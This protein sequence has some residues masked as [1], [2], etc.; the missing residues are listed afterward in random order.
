MSNRKTD[1]LLMVA[2]A[3]ALI[4]TVYVFYI[5]VF[6]QII[7]QNQGYFYAVI[8]GFILLVLFLLCNLFT[9]LIAISV[10]DQRTPYRKLITTIG[11]V[12]IAGLFLVTRMRY[13][14]SLYPGDY[15]VFRGAAAMAEGTYAENL[16]LIDSA[17]ANPAHYLCSLLLSVVFRIVEPSATAFLWMNAI[18]IVLCGFLT[19]KIVRAFTNPMCGLFSA[20]V[21]ACVPSQTFA[22]YSLNTEPMVAAIYLGAVLSLISLFSYNKRVKEKEE[23][24]EDIEEDEKRDLAGILFT[25]LGT[26]LI[27]LLIFVEPFMIIPMALL[28]LAAY[29]GRKMKALNMLVAFAAGIVVMVLLCF[30]KSVHMDVDFGTVMKSEV[31]AFDPSTNYNTG[32]VS[33][34]G[35]VY[36]SFNVD[37]SSTDKNITENYMF[38]ST[39]D[40]AGA[41]TEMNASWVVV[42]NQIMY[43]FVLMMTISCMILAVKEQKDYVVTIST[44]IVGAFLMLFFQQNRDNQ[45]FL[46]IT[47]F[48]IASSTGIHYLYLDHHPELKVSVNALDALEKTGRKEIAAATRSNL[49]NAARMSEA[50]FV[51]RAKAL[52]FVGNDEALY[53]QIKDEEHERAL[54]YYQRPEKREEEAF[55]DYDDDFFLDNE[56]DAGD[57]I[58]VTAVSSTGI[59]QTVGKDDMYEPN[60]EMHESASAA[61]KNTSV[62]AWKRPEQFGDEE[63]FDEDD[64]EL[65]KAHSAFDGRQALAANEGLTTKEPEPEVQKISRTGKT[66]KISSPK[67]NKKAV[68]VPVPVKKPVP[69]IE[70]ETAAFED[71]FGYN[72]FDDMAIYEPQDY[73]EPVAAKPSKTASKISKKDAKKEAK[74]KPKK[75][76][77]KA[78]KV[79]SEASATNTMSGGKAVRRIKT[80]GSG[81]GTGVNPGKPLANPLPVPEKKPHKDLDYDKDVK[82]ADDDGWDFDVDVDDSDDWDI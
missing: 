3:L 31:S 2:A 67:S 42:L 62:P 61:R 36:H 15:P 75:E 79:S 60:A 59:R 45:E 21:F 78:V 10:G 9:K 56:D 12:V 53:N 20:I 68:S 77:A 51:K 32:E 40:G 19:Y 70:P 72:D 4:A 27:G 57:N 13:N 76:K 18:F 63:M 16:D 29:I 50:D 6:E 11:L 49:K 55:D 1:P 46:F 69:V 39:D 64:V 82:T 37:L 28:V 38:I 71:D 24:Y 47:V 17:N 26:V 14:T 74:E 5:T 8:F 33:D 65:G 43:M 81:D 44:L 30:V 80:V 23:D 54:K 22:V 52:I 34:F 7:S 25:V 48:I 73:D 41:Y 35:D 66:K 58:R